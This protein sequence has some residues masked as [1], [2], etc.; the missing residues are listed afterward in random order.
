[1]TPTDR[2]LEDLLRMAHEAD[3]AESLLSGGAAGH[4]PTPPGFPSPLRLAG[5]GHGRSLGAWAALAAG[6]A[7]IA[8][9]GIWLSANP[10]RNAPGIASGARTLALGPKP[11]AASADVQPGPPPQAV[12][13][14]EEPALLER[15]SAAVL[16]IVQDDA[17][18]LQCVQW[19]SSPWQAERNL[20]DVRT[21]ELRD[22]G[23]GM[24]C[25]RAARRVLVVGLE[26]PTHEMPTSDEHAATI[27][28]C[29]LHSPHGD[30]PGAAEVCT[31]GTCMPT[32]VKM[33]MESVALRDH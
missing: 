7:I 33:R 21:D 26:G 10:T 2:Q 6:V 22:L 28:R 24:L 32:S 19:S 11:E 16:A 31:P 3:E 25:E 17:G 15:R 4:R 29:I 1:M 5:A 27:A 9:G 20:A 18:H 23:V 13:A 14:N 12:A 30:L 8:S